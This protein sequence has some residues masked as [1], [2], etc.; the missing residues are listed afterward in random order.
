MG[1]SRFTI[2]T[3]SSLLSMNMG[4]GR[5]PFRHLCCRPNSS[6]TASHHAPPIFLVCA[7]DSTKSLMAPVRDVAVASARPF[8]TFLVPWPLTSRWPHSG[9]DTHILVFRLCTA[10][11]K[12]ELEAEAES[13]PGRRLGWPGAL[14]AALSTTLSDWYSCLAFSLCSCSLWINC[15]RS[16]CHSRSFCS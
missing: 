12:K 13:H 7:Q 6:A 10:S 4:K 16:C 3:W 2:R 1:G 15:I 8:A 9:L 14:Q 5:K 11:C